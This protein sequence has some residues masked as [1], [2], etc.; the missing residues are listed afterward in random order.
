[1]NTIEPLDIRDTARVEGWYTRFVLWTKTNPQVTEANKTAFYLTMVGKEAFHLISDLMYPQKPEDCQP[2]EMHKILKNYLLPSNHELAEVIKFSSITRETDESFSSFVLRVQKQAAKCNFGEQL[3]QQM[4][5]RIVAGLNNPEMQKRIL[6]DQV[7]TFDSVK[8]LLEASQVVENSSMSVSKIDLERS[9]VMFANRTNTKYSRKPVNFSKS[10]SRNQK[11]PDHHKNFNACLSCGQFHNRATCKF[12]QSKCYQCNRVGHIAKVCKQ[13]NSTTRNI[14]LVETNNDT[15]KNQKEFETSAHNVI[16]K[17]EDLSQSHIYK[18]LYF[19]NGSESFILDTGSPINVICRNSFAKISSNSTIVPVT[20][21]LHGFSGEKIETLGYCHLITKDNYKLKFHVVLN[22]PN[23][24]GLEGMRSLRLNMGTIIP[25]VNQIDDISELIQ[26]ASSNAGGLKVTP[27]NINCDAEPVFFRSRSIAY[28]LRDAVQKTIRD[29]CQSGILEQVNYSRW[30]TPI[31]VVP[32]KNGTVR[33]C[34]DYRITLNNYLE[35]AATITEEPED[36]FAQLEGNTVFTKIDLSNAFHQIPLN[37]RSQELTTITTPYGMFRYRFLP[38]GLNISPGVFQ[39]VINSV[40]TGLKNCIAYQDDILVFGKD[41]IQHDQ[42]LRQ[43]LRRL[44][45]ANVQINSKKSIFSKQTISYLGY[46]LSKHGISPDPKRI[47]AIK[48]ASYP[49]NHTQLRSIIG[50]LQYYSR[51][52]SGFATIAEPLFKCQCAEKF[53]W[54]KEQIAAFHTLVDKVCSQPVLKCYSFKEPVVVTVDA[55]ETGIGG[56]LEQNKFPVI[57]VSRRL[58]KSEVNYSQTQKEALAI[59]WVIKRLHKFLFGRKFKIITDHN[60]LKYIF[61][62]KQSLSKCTSAMLSRWVITL[63]AYQYEIEHSPGRLIPQADFMSRYSKFSYE[64]KAKLTANFITPLPINR[65]DLI[66]ETKIG[67]SPLLNAL[68]K[69]WTSITMRKFPKIYQLREETCVT[70]DGLILVKD[71]P[72][73]PPTCR[74]SILTFLHSG[75]L[76]LQKMKSL[77]RQACFWPDMYNDLKRTMVN[78]KQCCLKPPNYVNWKPWPH[79][80]EPM[81]RIH[82]DYCG[83]FVSKYYALIIIDSF[84]KYPEVF[85]TTT[86]NSNFTKN[87]FQKF[88]SREGVPQAIVTDNGTH[89]NAEHLKTWTRSIGSQMVFTSPRHPQSNGLAENFVRT[90]KS[91][92]KTNNPTNFMQL[93]LC[94]DNFLMQ[95]RNAEHATTHKTPAFLFKGRNLRTSL[96]FPTTEVYFKKGNDLRLSQGIIVRSIGAV[97]FEIVDLEDGSVHRRHLDQIRIS[98]HMPKADEVTET[99][100]IPLPSNTEDEREEEKEKETKE[101]IMEIQGESIESKLEFKP[102]IKQTST[103]KKHIGTKIQ[104]TPLQRTQRIKKPPERLKYTKL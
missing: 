24:L 64:E 52:I 36:I 5:N 70:A 56:V 72:L 89:F 15:E 44:N 91:A 13:K 73:I 68:R 2:D 94:I 38:F 50:I 87:A 79:T 90:L 57:C 93:E 17:L 62:P 25:Y 48:L 6:T 31:V 23:L 51:F 92:I 80:I 85:L 55:S 26:V 22:G 53:H 77:A 9:H 59:V 47:E 32:K 34:G 12:R 61:N 76:G 10:V 19:Q 28:G 8:K 4:R 83:P 42:F 11:K 66:N 101:N 29:L 41:H 58:S 96:S 103:P 3:K 86:A 27:V 49:V 104:N 30:A 21:I 88:F 35:Q 39:S 14:R 69:G 37:K 67:L 54:G 7:V 45:D 98:K 1:M 102:N 99:Q 78:C 43:V 100:F 33:I 16:L 20:E 81:Q 63:S 65:N 46:L 84:S 40:L 97:M 95:Y 75:H 18:R 60:S 71:V 74:H 82:C